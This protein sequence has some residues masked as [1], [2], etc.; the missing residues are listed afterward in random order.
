MEMRSQVIGLMSE[1]HRTALK[2]FAARR[3]GKG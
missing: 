1:D 2:E 3:A